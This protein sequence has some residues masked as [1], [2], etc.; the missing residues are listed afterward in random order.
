MLVYIMFTIKNI[1]EKRKK[2][3]FAYIITKRG[4]KI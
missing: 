1:R 4:G 3:F 2:T